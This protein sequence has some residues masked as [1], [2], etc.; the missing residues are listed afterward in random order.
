MAGKLVIDLVANE[1][2]TAYSRLTIDYDNKTIILDRKRSGRSVSI[3][4][5]V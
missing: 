1:Q 3:N 4:S 2:R 5:L